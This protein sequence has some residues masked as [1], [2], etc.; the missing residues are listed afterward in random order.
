M[1][2]FAKTVKSSA[3]GLDVNKQILARDQQISAN[4]YR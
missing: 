3:R 1:G 4:F 2:V